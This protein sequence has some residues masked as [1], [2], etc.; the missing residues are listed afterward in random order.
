MAHRFVCFERMFVF[1]RF[2][3]VSYALCFNLY[4]LEKWPAYPADFSR[5]R[6][7]PWVKESVLRG[8]RK[9][10]RVKESVLRGANEAL[11]VR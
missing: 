4:V 11:I 5:T 6:K 10:P 7:G 9:G 3:L 1:I 2:C 8:A